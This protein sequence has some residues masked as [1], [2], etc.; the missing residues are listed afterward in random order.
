VV[1]WAVP[2]WT[3]LCFGVVFLV[4][5]RRWVAVLL[6]GFELLD[7]LAEL[8]VLLHQFQLGLRLD[9]SQ[10]V[11]TLDQVVDIGLRLS[12]EL[13]QPV[14]Q[15]PGDYIR[16]GTE[17]TLHAVD[18]GGLGLVEEHTDP[19]NEGQASS[20]NQDNEQKCYKAAFTHV[21]PP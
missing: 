10:M 17:H 20:G 6:L 15:I 11:E 4:P 5:E 19:K 16:G 8:G 2:C 9:L 3:T 18:G 7:P 1:L 12:L 14:S 13:N 21:A